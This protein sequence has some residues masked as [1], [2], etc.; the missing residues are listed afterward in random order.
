MKY[1][2]GPQIRQVCLFVFETFIQKYSSSISG[3]LKDNILDLHEHVLKLW[4]NR[5]TNWE[6]WGRDVNTCRSQNVTAK[7]LF[8]ED[9]GPFTNIDQL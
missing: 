8:G 6:K 3:I 5:S 7:V 9:L 4:T 1:L 2:C